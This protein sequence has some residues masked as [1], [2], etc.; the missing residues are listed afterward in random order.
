MTTK[1]STAQDESNL[2]PTIPVDI[3]NNPI[4]FSG[5]PAHI[6]GVLAE[7]KEWAT[8]TGRYKAL[9]ENG[10]VL[11]S[12]GALAVDSVQ[13]VQFVTGVQRDPVKYSL[14]NPCPATVQ[15]IMKYETGAGTPRHTVLTE[16]QVPEALRKS[17]IVQPYVIQKEDLAF[18]ESLAHIFE[19]SDEKATYITEC[20]GSGRKLVELLTELD[21]EATTADRTLVLT[22]LQA[23]S[24]RGMIEELNLASFNKY[25]KDFCKVHRN[26]PPSARMSE[27]N[28]MQL[29]NTAVMKSQSHRDLYEMKA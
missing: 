22:E 29:I 1:L 12:G 26:V 21:D 9:I 20:G 28:V 4:K 3:D 19:D 5:N 24:A 27:L 7:V 25:Y 2:D 8:R 10:A 16:P 18:M 6:L 23:F 11:L 15:R 13:A 17:Y 14:E